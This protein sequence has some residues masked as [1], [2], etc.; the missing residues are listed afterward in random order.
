MYKA[1]YFDEVF[2]DIQEAKIW[3]KMQIN[4]LEVEF[5]NAIKTA[6]DKVL[7]MPAL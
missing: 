6:I 4:G 2:T 5:A 1:Q 7:M 3:H